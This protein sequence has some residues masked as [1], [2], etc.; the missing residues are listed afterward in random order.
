MYD[1]LIARGMCVAQER[2]LWRVV[3]KVGGRPMAQEGAAGGH[4]R[5][6][7]GLLC[8]ANEKKLDL[9]IWNVVFAGSEGADEG[10]W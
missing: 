7:Q 5:P 2:K 8:F 1:P 4:V 9:I 3:P 6:H 10:M